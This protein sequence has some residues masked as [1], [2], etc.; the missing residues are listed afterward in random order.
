MV[1]Y[2]AII[3]AQKT[4]KSFIKLTP[5]YQSQF[6]SKF[7]NGNVFLKLENQQIT[8]SFK[9]RGAYNKILN[10]TQKEKQKGLITAS[11]GNHAQAVA[12]VAAKFN[13]PIKIIVPINT[14][15]NKLEKINK[16]PITL[17]LNGNNY[18]ESENYALKLSKEENLM[19]ISAYNDD[20]II[21]G[22]GT[23]GLEI[24][25]DMPSITDILVPL[26]GG[27]LLSGITIAVK[28]INPKIKVYGIQT[29]ACPTFYESLKVGEI[30]EV[31]MNDSIADGM[32][33]GIE[34]G[35]ITFDIIRD[36][37]DEVYL[38]KEKTIRKGIALLYSKDNIIAEGSA[39]AAIAP[40]LEHKKDFSNRNIVSIISGGNIDQDLLAKINQEF[41]GEII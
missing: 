35:S 37:V 4:I 29:E 11:S 1:N 3:E 26:G 33:G 18:D 39:A 38:V 22:Q 14:P 8:N 9:V 40:I 41:K 30:I 27:G 16:Y 6:L 5:L 31:K 12:L 19:Y 21:A 2:Q 10:L 25:Q 13:I 23:I 28:N 32:Y 36:F 34:K 15:F 24:L 17:E 7:C 20:L